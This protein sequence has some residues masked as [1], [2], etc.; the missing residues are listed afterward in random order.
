MWPY[1][2]IS[3]SM[4]ITSVLNSASSLLSCIFRVLIFSFI[5]AAFSF[6]LA[7]QLY[8]KGWSL[9]C[10]PGWDNPGHCVVVLYVREGL[11]REQCSLLDSS[12][13]LLLLPT[14]KFGPS[15]ADSQ[16]GGFVYVLGPCRSFQQTLLWGCESLR[17]PQSPQ[18]F[19]VRGFEALFPHART[20]GYVA[21]LASH[22]F[23][24]VYPH[25][26]VGPPSPPAATLPALVLQPLPCCTSSPPQLPDST[27]PTSLN[28]C[29]FF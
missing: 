18:I 29:F 3:V 13:L 24:P 26:N 9:R 12:Q 16:V 28:E 1:S 2:T 27:P 6:V 19:T 21:C 10:S 15:G 4:L 17:L 20:L 11:Q 8:Y 14:S 7:H 22:L 25:A 23:L 5:W